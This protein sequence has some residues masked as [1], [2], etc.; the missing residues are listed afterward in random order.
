MSKLM[1]GDTIRL[2]GADRV[3]SQIDMTP[4]MGERGWVKLDSSGSSLWICIDYVLENG[5]SLRHLG[6]PIYNML[7]GEADD[8]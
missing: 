4:M 2:D 7:E 8:T 3:V 5:R 6:T 1:V